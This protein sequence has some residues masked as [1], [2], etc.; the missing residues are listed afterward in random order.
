[1]IGCAIAFAVQILA[2]NRVAERIPP[3]TLLATELSVV[4]ALAWPAALAFEPPVF[5]ATPVALGALAAVVLLAS[6][7]ALWA[8]NWAQRRVSASRTAIVFALEPAFAAVTSWAVTGE[9][10]TGWGLLGAA[11]ILLAMVVCGRGGRT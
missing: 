5:R 7:G 6:V 1:M 9:R 11:A 4:A 8:Q 2:V 3:W 10:L